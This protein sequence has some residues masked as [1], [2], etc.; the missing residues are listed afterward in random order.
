MG[1]DYHAYMEQPAEFIAA[2]IARMQQESAAQEY[3]LMKA[4]G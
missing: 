4:R 1:W 3:W 2:I